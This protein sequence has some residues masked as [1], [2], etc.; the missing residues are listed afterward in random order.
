MCAHLAYNLF[1]NI[2]D[3]AQV[4]AVRQDQPI[5]TFLDGKNWA[6]LQFTQL[7]RGIPAGFDLDEAD[8]ATRRCGFHSYRRPLVVDAD[9]A[10]LLA[11]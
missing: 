8:E 1:S 11:A 10:T 6:F 3:H 9:Q 5:P 7:E 2:A 4:C